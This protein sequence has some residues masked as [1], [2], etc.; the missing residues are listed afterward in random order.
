MKKKWVKL[1]EENE[2]ENSLWEEIDSCMLFPHF[3][4]FKDFIVETSKIL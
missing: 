1:L 3:S 2:E 4:I